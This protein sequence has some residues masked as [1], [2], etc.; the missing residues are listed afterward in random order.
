M[1][2]EGLYEYLKDAKVVI[3]YY[4]RKT[5]EFEFNP[6]LRGGGAKSVNEALREHVSDFKLRYNKLK[7]LGLV[8]E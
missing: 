3:Q 8:G 2:G 1:D 5:K 6:Y 4:A 7:R